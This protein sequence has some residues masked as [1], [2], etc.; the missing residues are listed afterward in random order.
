MNNNN[1]NNKNFLIKKQKKLVF[2]RILMYGLL[3]FLISL[4]VYSNSLEGEFCFDDQFAIVNNKD[5]IG[6]NDEHSGTDS[7]TI[8]IPNT[9]DSMRDDEIFKDKTEGI[10]RNNENDEIIPMKEISIAY[11]YF[12]KLLSHDF[13]GQ[14]ITKTDSHKSYRPL[15]T[16][17]FRF[18]FITSGYKLDSES[19]HLTNVFLH[20]IVSVYIFFISLL[21]F[22]PINNNENENEEEKEEGK[23]ENEKKTPY[24]LKLLGVDE[25]CCFLTSLFFSLH[26]IHTEAVSGIV[27][28]AELLCTVFLMISLLS[29]LKCCNVNSTHWGYF[30]ISIFSLILSTLSKETG[31]CLVFI[32]PITDFL[33]VQYPN[34]KKQQQNS[35]NTSSSSPLSLM[36]LIR[37]IIISIVG[38]I[39]IYIRKLITVNMV[40]DNFRML[41]N[42]IAREPILLTRILSLINLHAR[43]LWLLIYPM[44]LSA[45]WSFNCIPLIKDISNPLNIFSILSYSIIL[46]T[47]IYYFLKI[48]FFTI[49]FK[50]LISLKN[51]IIKSKKQK[52]YNNNNNNNKNSDDEEDNNNNNNNNNENNKNNKNNNNKPEYYNS[53]LWCILFGII[54]FLP[55]SNIFFYVGTAIGERLLYIPSIAYCLLLSRFLTLPLIYL[56]NKNNIIKNNNNDNNN[57]KSEIISTKTE[58]NT[59]GT[60]KKRTNKNLTSS[61]SS[62]SLQSPSSSSSSSLSTN[63]KNNNNLKESKIYKIYLILLILIIILL[64]SFYSIKTWKRNED[65]KNEESLFLSA[66]KV[67]PNSAKVQY[68]VGILY[69]RTKEWDKSINHFNRAKE[70]LPDYCD[71]DYFYALTLI[72]KNGD[73]NHAK[74]YLNKSMNCRYTQ[75]RS[76][77]AIN[78]IMTFLLNSD[79][80]NPIL[81]SDWANY[82]KELQ[83]VNSAMHFHKAALIYNNQGDKKL[84]LQLLKESLDSLSRV[85]DTMLTKKSIER[86]KRIINE[87]YCQ[88]YIWLSAVYFDL[89]DNDQSVNS[90]NYIYKNCKNFK[91]I[92]N[93]GL[94]SLVNL[95]LYALKNDKSGKLPSVNEILLIRTQMS[96]LKDKEYKLGSTQFLAQYAQNYESVDFN[97]AVQLYEKLLSISPDTSSYYNHLPLLR[98]SWYYKNIKND[99]SQFEKYFKQLNLN[100]IFDNDL[101]KLFSE[102]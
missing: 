60:T 86:D 80:D 45:D 57:N 8:G 4:I 51:L 5:V 56:S 82:E 19:F 25:F 31:F 22:K 40:L 93:E 54:S 78:E 69:R 53:I 3:I 43:Y 30:F 77:E 70:I 65:W 33:L 16:L 15:T 55:S 94:L 89:Q 64:T 98:L 35:R 67:C 46:F 18:N 13:W 99:Q 6:Y 101:K 2:I 59:I 52:R 21:I 75:V 39:F 29:F 95:K 26:P 48:Q 9:M 81:L 66:L 11:Q 14:D 73:Y 27:G 58:S 42:P 91:K 100:L 102:L 63:I 62:S 37:T 17:S 49:I 32:L 44:D 71:V 76:L 34:F 88:D 23:E 41:E 97:K 84:A 83:P 7:S 1:K 96:Q 47:L 74:P 20:S 38:F 50:S 79:P 36:F 61:S 10:Y 87:L 85:N 72:N 24:L 12:S 90:L 28:R 68:N 92:W